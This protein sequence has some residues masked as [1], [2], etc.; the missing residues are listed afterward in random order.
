MSDLEERKNNWFNE[1]APRTILLSVIIPPM[2]G[3]LGQ[4]I[5]VN[6]FEIS[7]DFFTEEYNQITK[8]YYS[9]IDKMSKFDRE[10][11]PNKTINLQNT[12]FKHI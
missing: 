8:A 1:N 6:D 4:Y 2:N 12:I 10:K 11:H 7:Q 3:E 5:T 9:V